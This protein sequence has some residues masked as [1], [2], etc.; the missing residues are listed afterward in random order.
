MRGQEIADNIQVLLRDRSVFAEMIVHLGKDRSPGAAGQHPRGED[1]VAVAALFE[2][3]GGSGIARL[4]RTRRLRV[5][6][7]QAKARF[8]GRNESDDS[9]ANSQTLK[10]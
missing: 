10:V 1:H 8:E 4:Q 6:S 2:L 3:R 7:G 5:A 9:S